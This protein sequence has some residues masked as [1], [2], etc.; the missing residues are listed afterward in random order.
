MNEIRV[1]KK[2]SFQVCKWKLGAQVSF[3]VHESTPQNLAS[4]L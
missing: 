4:V 1:S 3:G 2:K